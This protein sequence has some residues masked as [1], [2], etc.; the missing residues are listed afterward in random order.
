MNPT[1]DPSPSAPSV[2]VLLTSARTL[3]DRHEHDAAE[4]L[5]STLCATLVPSITP[6]VW[7]E[8]ML[9]RAQNAY[10]RKDLNTT[11]LLAR[12]ALDTLNVLNDP[13]DPDLSRSLAIVHAEAG[14]ELHDSRAPDPQDLNELREPLEQHLDFMDQPD[15]TTAPGERHA[16]QLYLC[17][18]L[19]ELADDPP[20]AFLYYRELAQYCR[21]T[22]PPNIPDLY[23]EAL[24]VLTQHATYK[25]DFDT[26][27]THIDRLAALATDEPRA[28]PALYATLL[29][30][31]LHAAQRRR[32]HQSITL[33][34]AVLMQYDAQPSPEIALPCARAAEI[35]CLHLLLTHQPAQALQLARWALHRFTGTTN[36]LLRDVLIRILGAT[37]SA[38]TSQRLLRNHIELLLDWTSHPPTPSTLTEIYRATLYALTCLSS[39]NTTTDA[40]LLAQIRRAL[41]PHLDH[42]LAHRVLAYLPAPTPTPE[43]SGTATPLSTQNPRPTPLKALL[44]NA[45]PLITAL[46]LDATTEDTLHRLLLRELPIV[47]LLPTPPRNQ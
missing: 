4:R 38:H 25:G 47:H 36:P 11:R 24:R 43:T 23:A 1:T 10:A 3:T 39:Q 44:A 15:P 31:I 16:R 41:Q 2:D 46:R 14:L 32:H 27:E 13:T 18:R 33:C 21:D 40:P 22:P 30:L 34:R 20:N 28:R 6:S 42:P 45:D 37:L 7:I 12:H 9:L 19:H 8:A 5:L 29:T 26:T 35:L 17:A